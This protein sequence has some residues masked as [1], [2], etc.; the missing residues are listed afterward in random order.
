MKIA[1]FANQFPSSFSTYFARDMRGLI[2][3]GIEVEIFPIYPLDPK[4]WESVPEILNEKILPRS[5]V[6][7][8]SLKQCL[9]M[10]GL[11]SPTKLGRL[12]ADTSL[13]SAAAI[14]F[15]R[16]PWLKSIYAALKA[17]TWAQQ[18][19]NTYD[20]VLA[21]WGNHVGTAAY[22]YHRLWGIKNPFSVFLHAR[23]DL[24]RNPIYMRQKLL[25]ANSIITCSDFNR[26]Y[27]LQNFPELRDLILDKIFVHYHGLNFGEMRMRLDNRSPGKIIAVG[28]FVKHK[29]FDYLLRAAHLLRSRGVK[30]EIEL[31]GDG[32][33]ALALRSLARE[34]DIS[35]F[36][37]FQGW[38]PADEVPNA[39]GQATILVH[40][41]PD[42]GDGVPNVIKEAMAVGTPVIGSMV[43]GIPEL[44]DN[45]DCGMLVPPKNPTVL[46][47]A[48]QTM[49][50]D[51]RLREK[52]AQ[53]AR[54]CSEE[55]FDL[56]R[57][58]RR[59]AKVLETTVR[60]E[61]AYDSANY[62]HDL[63]GTIQ[64]MR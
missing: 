10:K 42:V 22:L 56:W 5:K 20:L 24:Y 17:W 27:I 9:G 47:D 28:R 3:A 34:L 32:E 15:G 52:Y 50:A 60:K 55:R 46:A 30:V 16:E 48:I 45:G 61:N 43:A 6:H 54:K 25:Y 36:V 58:G 35:D 44:L 51:D 63:S 59:L 38:L 37:N 4:L 12:L 49:L 11:R 2:E 41:S 18:Y 64:N 29:G 40:P 62:P 21:Y 13:V 8:L 53:A 1:V 33:E 23:V 57:N 26:E 7:H 31:V 39:I 14:K 19:P